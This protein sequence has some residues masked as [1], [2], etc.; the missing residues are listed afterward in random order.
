MWKLKIGNY[1]AYALTWLFLLMVAAVLAISIYVTFFLTALIAQ[2]AP[3]SPNQAC[4]NCHGNPGLNVKRDGQDIKLYLNP[5]PYTEGVHG[6]LD[7]TTCH[8]AIKGVPHQNPVYDQALW[9]EVKPACNSCHSGP[10]GAFQ[11]SIHTTDAT[12]VRIMP[13]ES[14]LSYAKQ[15][16]GCTGCQDECISYMFLLS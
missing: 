5:G 16:P 14:A 8:S 1:A 9:Q 13:R 7:C 2:A 4:L 11:Q 10:T 6:Q 12:K 15:R 3:I